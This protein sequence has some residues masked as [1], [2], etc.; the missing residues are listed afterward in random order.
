MTKGSDLLVAALENEGVERIFG[1]PGEENLDFL[2]SLAPRR[3]SWSSPGT[4]RARAS[5]PRPTAGTPARPACA[6]RTLGPGATNFVTA[7]GLRPARRHADADDHRPEAD[8]EVSRQARFQILDVVAMMGPIT[9]SPTS[10][11]APTTSRA[12]ARG[13]PPGRGGEA[14]AGPSR[15]AR[16]HRRRGDR[17]VPLCRRTPIARR[18]PTPAALDRAAEAIEAAEAPAG[19]RRRR[20]PQAARAGCC[21]SSS[22]RPASRS[23]P[24]RWA[25]A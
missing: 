14:R 18:S 17:D 6:S 1:V 22:R 24:P 13:L 19:D 4:S 16:G 21:S 20:Q 8:Q 7:G 2:E 3:S 5:W 11:P 12:G 15:A 25:R 23:S 9:N 10:S